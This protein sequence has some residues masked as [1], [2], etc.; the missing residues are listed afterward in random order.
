M[1][2]KIHSGMMLALLLIG[3]LTLAFNIQGARADWTWTETI[4]IRADGSV[5][6]DTAPISTV[7]NIIYTLTDNI[8]DAAPSSN[9][10]AVTIERDNV[11]LDGAGYTL[12]GARYMLSKGIDTLGR[13]NVTIR[14]MT[15]KQ[16]HYGVWLNYGSNN[17]VSGNNI[18][19]NE[20]G[21]W[22]YC[23]SD[24]TVSRNNITNNNWHGV[25]LRYRSDFNT[26]SGN[27]ITSNKGHGVELYW[28]SDFNTVSGNNITN[29][30]KDGVS[31]YE[32]SSFN[33]VS[34]N[35]IAN[36]NEDGVSLWGSNNTVSRNNITNNNRYGVR[37]FSG[38][39]NT[40]SGNSIANNNEDGVHLFYSSNN[41]VSG[42]SI[43]TNNYGVSALGSDFNT[44]SRN[45]IATNNYGVELFISSGNTF[46][47][48]NFVNH[49]QQVDS[50]ESTNIWDDSYP[51]GGN[52]W[53]DYEEKYPDAEELDGSGIWD[54][55]YE[56]DW[57]DQD[58]YP[59]MK[60]WTPTPP[61]PTTI[62]Q[63]K[64]E[65]EE[66]GIQDEIDNQGIVKSLIAKLNVA[67]KLVDKGKIDEAKSILEEDFIPQVQN[68]VN[69]HITPEVAE[70]L[71]ES[72]EYI[73]SHL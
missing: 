23:S 46:H 34:G 25:H 52:Y 35:S 27:N 32:S 53:S 15:I 67:Q 5:D 45:N 3:M 24:N 31:L 66:L 16:F 62:D 54:T 19:N 10:I 13:S 49:T 50:Y 26:V 36:N 18:T 17:T 57:N 12:Q 28:R 8:V 4:Y 14:N 72:A 21:V 30:N 51:S 68:L 37:L 22:V 6:P 58:N 63:L 38:S 56:I 61:I 1:R 33:T 29:N 11:I 9:A 70:I 55:P 43:T 65:I 69:I 64:T 59:L 44:V 73:L 39:S 20:V 60:P 42:N 2:K 71:I 7:D 41:T 48:N 47:H 40:V